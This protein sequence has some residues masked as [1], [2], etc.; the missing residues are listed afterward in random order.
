MISRVG[1]GLPA[2][3]ALDKAGCFQAITDDLRLVL[4]LAQGRT[5]QP[6]AAIFDSQ[7]IQSTPESGHR[8][9]YDGHKRRKGTKLHLAV[10]T[11]G[12][13]LAM[14]VTPANEQDRAQ[15]QPL[16]NAV[17]EATGDHVELVYVTRATRARS[18]PKPPP[19]RASNCMWS[20]FPTPNRAHPL[21]SPLGR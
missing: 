12:Q 17:Q 18:P 13:L 9:G 14:H 10:D 2:D 11:L 1:S 16:A 5:A 20:S 3:P 8:A 7:T 6:S 4:R 19:P 15:V 21:A